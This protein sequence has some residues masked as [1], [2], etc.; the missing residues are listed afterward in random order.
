MNTSDVRVLG[1]LLRPS[2]AIVC[3]ALALTTWGAYLA[4]IA[5]DELRG[6]YVVLLLCQS[7]AASTGYL[8]R[9]KRGH[10]DQVLAGR[11]TRVGFALV[12]GTLSMTLGCTTWLALSVIDGVAGG[13]WP[14]GLTPRSLVAFIYLSIV[15]WAISV[16]FS[17]YA[18]GVIWL[19]VAIT[20]AGSGRLLALRQTYALAEH[21]WRGVF[22]ATGAAM[23]FPPLVVGEPESPQLSVLALMLCAAL[24][25]GMAAVLFM[26]RADAPL[27][28]EE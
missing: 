3:V 20:L 4:V 27:E 9:A 13:R 23:V 1:V 12:H 25:T 16:P 24:V 10:F 26:V 8:T 15:A 22:R 28:D 18:A 14:L 7:F 11:S 2:N 17:R 19:V 5:P 21:T 6:P